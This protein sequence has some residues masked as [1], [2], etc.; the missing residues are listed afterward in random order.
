VDQLDAGI[1]LSAARSIGSSLVALSIS[2]SGWA[3]QKEAI[4][5]LPQDRHHRS[6]HATVGP[7]A[8]VE[9]SARGEAIN[10]RQNGLLRIF[11]PIS[12]TSMLNSGL[13]ID[14]P[15]T[16]RGRKARPI[17][18]NERNTSLSQFLLAESLLVY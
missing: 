2:T 6:R 12:P 1:N 10:Q 4:I 5:G 15:S 8:A 13:K 11:S 17:H 3:W 7:A 9:P 18:I 14:E 16:D